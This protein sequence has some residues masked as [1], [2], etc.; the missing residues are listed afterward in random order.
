MRRVSYAGGPR[1]AEMGCIDRKWGGHGDA[2]CRPYDG[3]DRIDGAVAGL[4]AARGTLDA[5]IAAIVPDGAGDPDA[6]YAA[7]SA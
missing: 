5:V 1:R 4:L 7:G 2:G 3:C 6:C